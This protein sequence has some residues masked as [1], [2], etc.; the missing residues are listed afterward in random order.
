MALPTVTATV[1]GR[2]VLALV[3]TGC[4]KS[5]VNSDVCDARGRACRV[6]TFE[7][8]SVRCAGETVASLSVEGKEFKSQCLVVERLLDGIGLILG[9]DVIERLGG[10]V[11]CRGKAKFGA[12]K[13]TDVANFAA[14]NIRLLAAWLTTERYVVQP[15]LSRGTSVHSSTGSRRSGQ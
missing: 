12:S 1:N 7:G 5:I 8:G 14:C 6:T 9:M 15:W 3:D 11:V 10:V 13:C 2:S 4:S